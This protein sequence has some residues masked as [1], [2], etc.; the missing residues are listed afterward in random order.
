MPRGIRFAHPSYAYCSS[1]VAASRRAAPSDQRS[2]REPHQHTKLLA[3][4][5]PHASSI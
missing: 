5:A 1:F 2:D 3:A 4:Q